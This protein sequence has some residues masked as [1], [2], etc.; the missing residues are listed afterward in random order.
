MQDPGPTAEATF[1]R[2][3]K[4]RRSYLGLSQTDLAERVVALGGNLYQQTIAKIEAGQRAIKLDEA[5]ALAAALGATVAEMLVDPGARFD[6][7]VDQLVEHE[8]SLKEDLALAQERVMEAR[9]EQ[10]MAAVK[11][12]ELQRAERDTRERLALASADLNRAQQDAVREQEIRQAVEARASEGDQARDRG[13]GKSN[14]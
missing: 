1:V 10:D 14:E 11:L 7:S 4:Q 9:R 13:S 6:W 2:Q 3:M 5:D 8:M 12:M